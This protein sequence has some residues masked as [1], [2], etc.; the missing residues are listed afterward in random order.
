M[1]KLIIVLLA[2]V[3]FGCTSSKTL[4]LKEE[5]IETSRNS[6]KPEWV[7]K[8][9]KESKGWYEFSGGVTD[10]S[11]Y[12]LGVSEA[13]AEAVKNG[14]I[15]IQIKAKSEFSKVAEGSNM[16]PDMTGKW[17]TDGISFLAE[18]LYV[19][20]IIQKEIFSE[21]AR[22]NTEFRPH[23]NIWV[24]CRIS[25]EDY[26]KAKIDAA[27]RLINKYQLEKNIEA[28]EKAEELLDSIITEKDI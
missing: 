17:V 2:F 20:G 10:V 3:V 28:K 23:F 19:S 4:L 9:F 26:L 5:I 13:R 18:S 7:Y 25:S 1:K 11:D 14:I 12:A 22:Y 24:L 27:Q 8:T 21:K 16:A 6:S 15:S